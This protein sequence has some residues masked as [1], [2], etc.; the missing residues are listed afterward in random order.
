MFVPDFVRLRHIGVLTLLSV[1]TLLLRD[2]VTAQPL[3]VGDGEVTWQIKDDI[4]VITYE[5]AV[6]LD[7]T[8]D[9]HVV[10]R[11]RGDRNFWFVPEA[12]EGDVGRLKYTGGWRWIR[13]D[14]KKDFG[15]GFIGEDYYFQINA[16]EIPDGGGISWWVYAVGGAAV[17]VVGAILLLNRDAEPDVLPEPPNVRPGNK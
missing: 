13:W 10:L 15:D 11:R 7:K 12:T 1:M 14:Y 4:I 6:S 16:T 9:I 5:L 17:A 8:Y 2:G 3:T